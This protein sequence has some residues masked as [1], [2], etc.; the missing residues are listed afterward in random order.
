MNHLCQAKTL[1]T[2]AVQVLCIFFQ[3]TLKYHIHQCSC[4]PH[5]CV[6][7]FCLLMVL[8]WNTTILIL[9]QSLEIC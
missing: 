8:Y 6:Y 5:T 2:F 4:E 9:N 1:C 3:I 7:Q